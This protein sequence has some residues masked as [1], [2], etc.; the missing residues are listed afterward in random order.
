MAL[1]GRVWRTPHLA[2]L[3]ALLLVS[4]AN[5]SAGFE[6]RSIS[7]IPGGSGVNA[8][9]QGRFLMAQGLALLQERTDL[10]RE[11]R[12]S[13]ARRLLSEAVRL[14]P[15]LA[16]AWLNLAIISFETGECARAAVLA[17]TGA[18]KA[19]KQE[20]AQLAKDFAG[21]MQR[22][23][24]EPGRCQAEADSTSIYSGL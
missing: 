16:E 5:A 12:L 20:D 19:T 11:Q 13:E 7:Q 2:W 21:T 6:D 8:G 4:G 15:D 23:A 1:L 3:L 14:N 9:A 17:A 10:P 22:Y 18:Q 24:N